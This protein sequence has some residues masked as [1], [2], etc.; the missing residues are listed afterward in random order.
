MDKL[1]LLKECPYYLFKKQQNAKM[2]SLN[3][4]GKFNVFSHQKGIMYLKKDDVKVHQYLL[5]KTD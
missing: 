3:E 5:S 1:N 2:V 4:K